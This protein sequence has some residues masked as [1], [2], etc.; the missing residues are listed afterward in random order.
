[1]KLLKSILFFLSVFVGAP[2]MAQSIDTN[3][4]WNGTTFISSFGV[5]DTATYG[6]IITIFTPTVLFDYSFQIGNC[7]APVTFRGHIY[8][9]NG[10][11]ATGASLYDSPIQNVPADAFYHRVTFTPPAA[12]PLNAGQ[13]VLFASTSQDQAA[14]PASA[15]RWGAL[16]NNTTYPFG[17]FVF[18]NNNTNVAA[19]TSQA[20]SN[21]GEDLAF[22]ATFPAITPA[23]A[24]SPWNLALLV[25]LLLGVAMVATRW[26][27]ARSK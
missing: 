12:V 9:W 27:F 10:T 5:T 13:Y 25:L 18:L 24:L 23:P 11:Q 21:I 1:M 19:W 7:S 6:Q 22:S 3:P 2:A 8:A 26:H 17:Q 15:C 16:T 20:W 4:Q 14:A